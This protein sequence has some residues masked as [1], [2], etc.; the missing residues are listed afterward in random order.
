MHSID[1]KMIVIG[2]KNKMTPE[3]MLAYG[4]SLGLWKDKPEMVSAK[5]N[6]IYRRIK[7]VPLSKSP[8]PSEVEKPLTIKE[9]LEKQRQER[10]QEL[11]KRS[12][13]EKEPS[14][15]AKR[16]AKSVSIPSGTCDIG[17]RR[18]SLSSIGQYAAYT[19]VL[20]D[21]MAEAGSVTRV[22]GSALA[23]I[24]GMTIRL[25][26]LAPAAAAVTLGVLIPNQLADGTLYNESEIRQR[27]MVETNV[28]LGVDDN[29][30]LYGYHVNGAAIPRRDVRQMGDKFVVDLEPGITIEWV[31]MSGDFGGK[32]ILINP[33]PD[34]EK[35]DAWV[36]PPAEQGKE[37][38]KTYITPIED[39]DLNDYILTFPASTGLPPLYVVY[40]ESPRNESGIVTGNG[41]DVT[42]RWLEAAGKE[43][44]SPVPSQI[45][46]KLRGREFSSFDGFRKAFWTE[47]S[48]DPELIKQFRPGN[49]GNLKSG[50]APIAIPSEWYGEV[51]RYE[52]HHIEEIQHGGA[53]Y[54]VDNMRIVTPKNHKRIHYK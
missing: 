36:H 4:K 19:A 46:D 2:R 20:N 21:G 26:G 6:V 40:K 32:P 5:P 12:L 34:V 38:K 49:R 1:Y 39:A 50:N 51:K 11:E 8:K 48:K 31:P 43:L 22:V 42:G 28:R 45:A 53:V 13:P 3:K 27:T 15:K 18:E 29:G 41:E 35:L 16:F 23:D 14:S 7:T 33:I 25:I 10:Y 54:D 37:F 9:R 17:T 30:H 44:G 52:I 47:V 24:E